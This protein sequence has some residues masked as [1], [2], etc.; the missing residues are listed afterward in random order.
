VLFD[1]RPDSKNNTSISE[2][3]VRKSHHCKR[4]SKVS[5][6]SN[7]RSLKEHTRA[8][9]FGSRIH[10]NLSDPI[11]KP[12]ISSRRD[13]FTQ[14]PT[15]TELCDKQGYSNCTINKIQLK[16]KAVQAPTSSD[17]STNGDTYEL[18][19]DMLS[20]STF[21][22]RINVLVQT[23]ERNSIKEK[24]SQGSKV[25]DANKYTRKASESDICDKTAV[26][27]SKLNDTPLC[28]CDCKKLIAEIR[29]KTRFEKQRFVDK[30]SV[31]GHVKT[32]GL[33]SKH[34]YVSSSGRT[35]LSKNT[36]DSSGRSCTVSSSRTLGD[37]I[38]LTCDLDQVRASV[39]TETVGNIGAQTTQSV[40][41]LC[42]IQ[43][44][45]YSLITKGTQKVS[46][47]AGKN[48]GANCKV[49]P[50]CGALEDQ[51][52]TISES[53]NTADE[54][55][56]SRCLKLEQD[57]ICDRKCQICGILESQLQISD[58]DDIQKHGISWKCSDCL[59]RKLDNAKR[60]FDKRVHSGLQKDCE[61]GKN[62]QIDVDSTSNIASTSL[63]SP[64][65]YILTLE[66][67]T[68][69]VCSVEDRA[70]KKPLE[71]IKIKVTERNRHSIS[72][73]GRRKT[74]EKAV[75]KSNV[76]SCKENHKP[77]GSIK[78]RSSSEDKPKK[79]KHTREATLQ[80]IISAQN[81][82]SAC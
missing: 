19:G 57:K 10:Q 64:I 78:S 66:T 24:D 5:E 65:G 34:K 17:V 29:S 69:S 53:Q 72:A 71:E 63:K 30:K 55:K 9:N 27:Q 23:S 16:E 31:E 62:K 12:A 6:L 4:T 43:P 68:D 80:V 2:L 60:V 20:D 59:T 50:C 70:V 75:S 54:W 77:V 41:S 8:N 13:I 39:A 49:C 15:S 38:E 52:E 26:K 79:N 18:T 76:K 46:N 73:K 3:H 42:P 21:A 44:Q 28:C 48:I 81:C 40:S 67:S 74:F 56:C 37:V 61:D 1:F 14:F 7:S 33:V 11:V 32:S 35:E 58:Q 22:G 47:K 25:T 45:W 36:D 82:K 51:N